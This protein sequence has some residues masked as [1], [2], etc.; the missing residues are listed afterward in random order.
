M[1]TEA[2]NVFEASNRWISSSHPKFCVLG[3]MGGC[4]VPLI[5]VPLLVLFFSFTW[6][7]TAWLPCF[8]ENYT[9]LVIRKRDKKKEKKNVKQ[10]D[11]DNDNDGEKNEQARRIINGTAVDSPEV[12]PESQSLIVNIPQV[13]AAKCLEIPTMS[14]EEASKELSFFNWISLTLGLDEDQVRNQAGCDAVILIGL[15]KRLIVLFVGLMIFV[16][17]PLLILYPTYSIDPI[18]PPTDLSKYRHE[19]ADA[20]A[21]T[22][23]QLN[24]RSACATSRFYVVAALVWVIAIGVLW[25]LSSMNK[26]MTNERLIWLSELP[27]P[28]GN[29]LIYKQ[30]PLEKANQEDCEEYLQKFFPDKIQAVYMCREPG[31]HFRKLYRRCEAVNRS[32]KMSLALEGL[33]LSTPPEEIYV[34]TDSETQ[35]MAKYKESKKFFKEY[36]KMPRSVSDKSSQSAHKPKKPKISRHQKQAK[37]LVQIKC[38]MKTFWDEEK[39]DL[40]MSEALDHPSVVVTF[41]SR[42]DQI[43]AST[44]TLEVDSKK[45]VLHYASSPTDIRYHDLANYESR[46]KRRHIAYFWITAI[47]FGFLPFTM[48]ISYVTQKKNVETL[49]PFLNDIRNGSS[50][51][52][53]VVDLI[54][55]L[56]PALMLNIVIDIM[57]HVF[58]ALG[59]AFLTFSSNT[60]L[61]LWASKLYFWFKFTFVVMGVLVA[62]IFWTI[63]Q[64]WS[65][66]TNLTELT[67]VLWN[68]A[69]SAAVFGVVMLCVLIPSM[70]LEFLIEI[71]RWALFM[72]WK[73]CCSP[74]YAFEKTAVKNLGEKKVF[75]YMSNL[76]VN[77]MFAFA[78]CVT[79]SIILPLTIPVVLIFLLCLYPIIK[80]A[81]FARLPKNARYTNS[82]GYLWMQCSLYMIIIMV[83]FFIFMMLVCWI[84]WQQTSYDKG[85]DDLTDVQ[86]QW[87]EADK[88]E[89]D[90]HSVAA[91]FICAAAF[92]FF[93]AFARLISKS[94]HFENL[95][96]YEALNKCK[97]DRNWATSDSSFSNNANHFCQ[98]EIDLM[99][100]GIDDEYIRKHSSRVRE[101]GLLDIAIGTDSKKEI[102]EGD[103][104]G[105]KPGD[106]PTKAAEDAYPLLFYRDQKE[107]SCFSAL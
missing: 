69:P 59:D 23:L 83:C 19:W 18:V 85:S 13:S 76:Y 61:N 58:L 30:L 97:D 20:I 14:A 48:L 87:K 105:S 79:F 38:E 4:L 25:L 102:E 94:T 9:L 72:L 17:T 46:K 80:F 82:G 89:V 47:F 7:F 77:V 93:L 44:A 55:Q 31:H 73:W 71:K 34:P 67:L 15:V 40:K 32:Y 36:Q 33:P 64:D 29:G 68:Q 2:K 43:M 56:L 65:K 41:K 37:R 91:L 90:L 50:M 74:E 5:T 8:A 101:Y 54:E 45:P 57:I 106:E 107:S 1:Q 88:S 51:G 62:K 49:L 100:N 63:Q 42:V 35:M 27:Y 28:I 95:P 96:L 52:E 24:A 81:F 16:M 86:L 66:I 6:K 10:N 104:N 78:L 103:Q 98:P 26:L 11:D 22:S 92:L 21:I 75:L 12:D 53:W 3:I 84:R 70:I 39:L 99:R 60:N